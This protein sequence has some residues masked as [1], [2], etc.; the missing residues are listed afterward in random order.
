MTGRKGRKP[1][2]STIVE[3]QRRE[4]GSKP[5]T[6]R[7]PPAPS[8]LGEVAKSEWRRLGRLLIDAG[9]LTTLDTAA[10]AAYCMAYA[11]H[12]AAETMLQGPAGYCPNCDP[13]HESQGECQGSC[14]MRPEYGLVINQQGGDGRSPYVAIA[15]QAL[16]QMIRLLGELGMTP[17]SRSRI[18]KEKP[19][20]R[21]PRRI[22]DAGETEKD[23]RYLLKMDIQASKN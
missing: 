23:P 16:S 7:L 8:H 9:L 17:A 13:R 22:T 4:L 3:R 2:A 19:E 15:N 18:P 14:H 12:V 20:D 5:Q 11:R 6:Q 10:L 1:K 21:R